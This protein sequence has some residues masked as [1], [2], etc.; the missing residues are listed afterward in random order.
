MD[1]NQNLLNKIKK[2]LCKSTYIKNIIKNT[3]WIYIK[4]KK[5]WQMNYTNL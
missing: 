2:I 1:T 4:Y 5:T 3:Y